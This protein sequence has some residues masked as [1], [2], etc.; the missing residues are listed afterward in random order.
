MGIPDCEDRCSTIAD[1]EAEIDRLQEQLRACGS[2]QL[3]AEQL[4]EAREEIDS[5]QR[6]LEAVRKWEVAT[7]HPEDYRDWS[8][9]SLESL[10][11]IEALDALEGK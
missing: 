8:Q 4:F 5:L 3:V 11:L 1:L 9:A 2:E 10:E 7:R 6:V